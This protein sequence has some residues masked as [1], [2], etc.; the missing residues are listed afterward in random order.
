MFILGQLD[1]GVGSINAESHPI[2][3]QLF[4]PFEY[5]YSYSGRLEGRRR[6]SKPQSFYPKQHIFCMD[7]KLT[8]ARTFEPGNCMRATRVAYAQ[9]TTSNLH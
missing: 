6:I 4:S 3:V 2:P 8:A 9:P 1:Y 5:G 7:N